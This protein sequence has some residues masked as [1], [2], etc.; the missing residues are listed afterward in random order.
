MKYLLILLLFP[1]VALAH[2][3]ED[4]CVYPKMTSADGCQ[5]ALKSLLLDNPAYYT[6]HRAYWHCRR[7]LVS[8]DTVTVAKCVGA[9]QAL[10]SLLGKTYQ[11]SVLEKGFLNYWNVVPAH[12]EF[13]L[14][15]TGDI[16]QNIQQTEFNTEA[17]VL[18]RLAVAVLVMPMC[19]A[20]RN[21]L[22]SLVRRKMRR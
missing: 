7:E 20:K 10:S 13:D 17:C 22:T 19:N 4:I 18:G 12:P 8:I 11:Q 15:D 16:W 1:A 3:A 14:L 5:P 2:P 6:A 21:Y 9:N